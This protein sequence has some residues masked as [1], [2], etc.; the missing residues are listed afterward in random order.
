MEPVRPY[1]ISN[2]KLEH[3]KELADNDRMKEPD[4]SMDRI[5]GSIA[6]ITFFTSAGAALGYSQ[7]PG[8]GQALCLIGLIGGCVFSVYCLLREYFK[9]KVRRTHREQLVQEIDQIL[10]EKSWNQ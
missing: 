5:F 7:L 8:Y 10:K 9:N 1:R 6:G 4:W 3:L 2:S